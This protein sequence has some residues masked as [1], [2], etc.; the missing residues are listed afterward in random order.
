MEL[1]VEFLQRMKEMLGEEYEDFLASYDQERVYGLRLNTLKGEAEALKRILPFTLEPIPWCD[2]GFYYKEEER[3]GKQVYHEA[4]VYYIQEP[5]AMITAE[6][7]QVCPGDVVLDLCAAP[8]GKST[9]LACKLQG[10]GL[11]ISNEIN[12][13]R[14]AI[15]SQNIERMGVVNAV[16]MNES[17]QKLA[18]AF[19]VFFDKIVVDAPCSGEGMFKKEA[20]AVG[21][22]SVA[23]VKNCAQRQ[24]EILDCAAD[25]LKPGGRLVYST[26]TFAVEENEENMKSFVKR[27]PEFQVESM[28]R[29]WPHKEKGEGH[30]AAVLCKEG[31]L[32]KSKAVVPKKITEKQLLKQYETF[33]RENMETTLKGSTVLFGEQLYILPEFC[34]DLKGL[35][36]VRPGLHVGTVKKNRIEPAYALSHGITPKQWKKTLEVTEKQA[37]SYL[38]GETIAAD[39]LEKGWYLICFQGFPLGF[40]KYSGGI[41]K[42]HYPKGLRILWGNPS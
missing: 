23:N 40:G 4:G 9:Q 29:I 10:E 17:P 31:S 38:M 11:L 35:K 19:P 15:L 37:I 30:F 1:P 26:C 42:N 21:E 14:A 36:V 33:V 39:D 18:K 12:A 32:V 7:A 34:P 3:P 6:L 27:H 28:H 41:I 13:K 22:W 25:M 20:A 16:V 8:G 2:T 24:A 5:S